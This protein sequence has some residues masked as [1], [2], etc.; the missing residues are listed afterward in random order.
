MMKPLQMSLIM[1]FQTLRVFFFV[2]THKVN[3]FA[4]FTIYFYGD[5]QESD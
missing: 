2:S 1:G 5:C 3:H 4:Y